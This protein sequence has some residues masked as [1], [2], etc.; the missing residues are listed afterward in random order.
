M[1]AS[2]ISADDIQ[3]GGKTHSIKKINSTVHS[4]SAELLEKRKIG[5]A[6][7]QLWGRL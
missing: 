1:G 5:R 7:R 3:Y 2:E 4:C 6:G